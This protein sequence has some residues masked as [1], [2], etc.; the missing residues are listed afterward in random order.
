VLLV[1]SCGLGRG[2]H[3][4]R[5]GLRDAEEQPQSVAEDLLGHQVGLAEDADH[6][7]VR[8]VGA[9]ELAHP[10]A[11]HLEPGVVAGDDGEIAGHDLHVV[12]RVLQQGLEEVFLVGK[13]QVERAVRDPGP[14]H[15]VVDAHAVEATILEF[16]HARVEQPAHGLAALGAQL[17]VLGG[18]TPAQ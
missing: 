14:A 4:G 13:V 15:H 16:D 12:Q 10:L 5:H 8:G 18:G 17:T 3:A 11:Q 7:G 2:R 6:R 1:F 9:E